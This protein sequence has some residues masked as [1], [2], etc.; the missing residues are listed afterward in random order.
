VTQFSES[1]LNRVV[2]GH[3]EASL[4]YKLTIPEFG[5]RAGQFKL[6]LTVFY[7]TGEEADA[8]NYSNTFVNVTVNVIEGGSG[9]D[10]KTCAPL[11][12]NPGPH[13]SQILVQEDHR[14]EW[15]ACRG[16]GTTPNA[17]HP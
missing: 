9:I 8:Q 3:T 10:G 11:G 15:D 6:A 12:L 1:F 2:E 5:I 13:R 17:L 7:H 16:A 14:A 4:D